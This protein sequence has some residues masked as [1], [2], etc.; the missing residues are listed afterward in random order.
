MQNTPSS[1]INSKFSLGNYD[2]NLYEIICVMQDFLSKPSGIPI[3]GIM[4]SILKIFISLCIFPFVFILSL[5]VSPI[6][7]SRNNIKLY[8]FYQLLKHC[9]VHLFY[10]TLNVLTLGSICFYYEIYLPHM[11]IYKNIDLPLS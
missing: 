5:V 7:Y 3:I 11:S 8:V 2:T 4:A 9:L 1:L 10:A 6:A